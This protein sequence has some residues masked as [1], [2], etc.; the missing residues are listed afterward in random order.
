M[1]VEVEPQRC[2]GAGLCVLTVPEVFSQH[3]T[4]GTVLL[5]TPR[6]DIDQ[7]EAVAE[8]AEFCPSGAIK[9]VVAGDRSGQ[10]TS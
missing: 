2:C 7:Q 6:P 4:D 9:I 1:L 3:E 8:A 10:R 5:L